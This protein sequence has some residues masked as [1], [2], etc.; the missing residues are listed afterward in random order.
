MSLKVLIAADDD[1]DTVDSLVALL[2]FMGCEVRAV[3][4]AETAL[5]DACQFKPDVILVDLTMPLVEIPLATKHFRQNPAVARTRLVALGRLARI[6]RHGDAGKMDFDFVMDS[7]TRAEMSDVMKRVTDS[8]LRERDH[9]KLE[10]IESG[11]PRKR[12]SRRW[13]RPRWK[14]KP[15]LIRMFGGMRDGQELTGEQAEHLYEEL[16]I[17][18]NFE[19]FD[20]TFL[21]CRTRRHRQGITTERH[22]YY[23]ETVMESAT[24]IVIIARYYGGVE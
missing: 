10:Q 17:P 1:R 23:V 6:C 12:R 14:Q 20:R 22:R 8:I 18:D 11:Q 16:N 19:A 13:V 21:A 2:R 15:V 24:R 4:D 9:V 3:S 7:C 5:H